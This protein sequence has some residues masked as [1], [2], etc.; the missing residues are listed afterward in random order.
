MV[1]QRTKPSAIKGIAFVYT[2][3]VTPKDLEGF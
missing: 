3:N 1:S 2:Y